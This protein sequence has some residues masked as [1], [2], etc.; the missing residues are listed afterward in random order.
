MYYQTKNKK[1]EINIEELKEWNRNS[2]RGINREIDSMK[3]RLVQFYDYAKATDVI[4][5]LISKN[6]DLEEEVEQKR[7]EVDDLS[8]QLEQKDQVIADLQ[9]Q[10][11]EAQNLQLETEKQQLE[12]EKQQLEAEAQKKATEIHNHFES[13]CS[14]QVFNDKVTG[15]FT[16][17]N[18]WKKKEKEKKR[19]W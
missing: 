8:E 14:A 5:A 19:L 4:D 15:K 11:L 13:G 9:R 10:L 2:K 7:E 17:K 1:M 16:K 6:D 3:E 18:R 12:S